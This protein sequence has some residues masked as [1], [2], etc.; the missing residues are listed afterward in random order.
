MPPT[1][2]GTRR[3]RGGRQGLDRQAAVSAPGRPGRAGLHRR[4]EPASP[5]PARPARA[6]ASAALKDTKQAGSAY[7]TI[8]ATPELL[9]PGDTGGRVDFTDYNASLM[10]TP[11][12]AS[13]TIAEATYGL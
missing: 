12:P 7:V 1:L 13:Q 11:P 8:S 9:Q 6:P 4:R 2:S 3:P 10:L 5:V